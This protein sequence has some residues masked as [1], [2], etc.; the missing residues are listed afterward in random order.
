MRDSCPQATAWAVGGPSQWYTRRACWQKQIAH[1]L[2]SLRPSWRAE[3]LS[4]LVAVSPNSSARS[5]IP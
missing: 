5:K 1:R 2:P 3:C 4:I